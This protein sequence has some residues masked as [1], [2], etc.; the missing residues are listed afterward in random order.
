MTGMPTSGDN[1]GFHDITNNKD[2]GVNKKYKN[3]GVHQFFMMLRNGKLSLYYPDP[4]MSQS[5][6]KSTS[7]VKIYFFYQIWQVKVTF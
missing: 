1:V 7:Q 5:K 6:K 4:P 3:K 2:N